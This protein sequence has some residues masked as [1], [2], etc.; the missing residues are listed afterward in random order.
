MCRFKTLLIEGRTETETFFR[1]FETSCQTPPSQETIFGK[2]T[3]VGMLCF[4][5]CVC[6]NWW[7]V[8][9]SSHT[10]LV[11]VRC[12]SFHYDVIFIARGKFM[13]AGIFI[14]IIWSK[15]EYI[16]VLTQPLFDVSV[17]KR[18]DWYTV[19]FHMLYLKVHRWKICFLFFIA[20]IRFN[21]CLQAC[22]DKVMYFLYFCL[23]YPII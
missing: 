6:F 14:L 1:L 10:F 9:C 15:P 5:S 18:P 16:F 8:S 23:Q 4:K 12:L 17:Q 3:G 11:P 22:F 7:P 20:F 21:Y 19:I 13:C 2:Q